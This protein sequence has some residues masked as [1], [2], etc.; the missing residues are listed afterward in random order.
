M[1]LI[2]AISLFWLQT[3]SSLQNVAEFSALMEKDY[4]LVDVR[5][6]EEYTNGALPNA[7]N[8]SVT[9]LNFPLEI[10]RLDKEKP[11]LIYCKSGARSARAAIAMKALGFENIYELDGGYLAWKA[12]GLSH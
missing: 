8:I 5:T 1:S 9:S 3:F 10:N 7:L 11:V 12:A 4:P 2:F 6:P